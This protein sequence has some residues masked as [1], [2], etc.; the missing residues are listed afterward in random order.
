MLTDIVKNGKLWLLSSGVSAGTTDVN[1]LEPVDMQGYTSV[2]FL[3]VMSTATNASAIRLRVRGGNTTASTAAVLYT[4]N[5]ASSAI[6]STARADDFGIA[7]NVARP[8]H[9]YIWPRVTIDTQNASVHTILAVAYNAN[10]SPTTGHSA[11]ISADGD[12]VS[13]KSVASPTT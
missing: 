4:T 7:L 8:L 5:F 13:A 11:A 12:W 9:R 10:D 6:T 3:V 2:A 1:G